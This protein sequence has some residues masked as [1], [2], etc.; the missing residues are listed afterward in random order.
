ML[1]ER[2]RLL[3]YRPHWID[4][5]VLIF[6]FSPVGSSLSNNFGIYDGLSN[7]LGKTL[8]WGIPY[9]LGRTC[10]LTLSGY[11]EL[12]IGVV[13]GGLALI[14]ICLWE[15]RMSPNL[16]QQVYGFSPFQFYTA[17]RLGGYR[18]VGFLQH[19]IELAMWMTTASLIS[20]W[21]W[22]TGSARKLLSVPFVWVTIG[23]LGVT[24]LCRSLG[25]MFLMVVALSALAEIRWLRKPFILGLLVVAPLVYVTARSMGDVGAKEFVAV[26][27]A[28]NKDRSASLQTR[29]DN[30]R[31]LVDHALKQPLFGWGGW[32]RNR[33]TRDGRDASLTDGL[34]VI[35][36][37]QQGLVG[38]IAWLGMSVAP[39]GLYLMRVR[40]RNLNSRALAPAT[41]AAVILV[42]HTNDWLM[43]AFTNP[44]YFLMSGGLVTLTSK[45][46][47]HK[48][49]L[50]TLERA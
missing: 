16:H 42:M 17:R 35:I 9:F 29:L 21:L 27:K 8:Q 37:G 25:A 40:P 46:A 41:V 24:V 4:L 14:P 1:F 44:T 5:F 38:L 20:V 48:G 33:I 50:G 18:P 12:V 10:F 30:D 11:R 3:D 13:I 45:L 19:G 2:Q 34:W 22:L 31:E 49:R 36:V 6:C 28:V 15:I 43:N 26:A 32:G 39:S 7:S 23:L 47:W